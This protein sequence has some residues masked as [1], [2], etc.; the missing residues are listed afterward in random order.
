G[1]DHHVGVASVW[2]MK[3]DRKAVRIGSVRPVRQVWYARRIGESHRHRDRVGAEY[4]RPAQRRGLGKRLEA[5]FG[6]D[7]LGVI[8]AEPWVHTKNLVHGID[9]LLLDGRI[10]SSRDSGPGQSKHDHRSKERVLF[11]DFS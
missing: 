1:I 6:D 7:T 2:Q 4:H 11:H 5:S 9:E 10:L 8:G 3:L